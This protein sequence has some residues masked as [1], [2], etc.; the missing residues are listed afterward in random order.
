LQRVTTVRSSQYM[1]ELMCSKTLYQDGIEIIL[2]PD[3]LTLVDRYPT[4][5]TDTDLDDRPPTPT[6]Q[7]QVCFKVKPR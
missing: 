2:D 7:R 3:A 4:D 1:A 6:Q 5:D